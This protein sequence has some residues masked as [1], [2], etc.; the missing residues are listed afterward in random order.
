VCASGAQL[1]KRGR[2]QLQEE[3]GTTLRQTT[4]RQ[5]TLKK[6]A[7]HLKNTAA[8]AVRGNVEAVA[9][10]CVVDELIIV[11]VKLLQAALNHVVACRRKD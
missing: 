6:H 5:T 9:G 8:V 2:Y 7:K 10:N 1:G 3:S 11:C 4:L